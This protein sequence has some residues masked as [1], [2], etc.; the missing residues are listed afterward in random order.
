MAMSRQDRN[1]WYRCARHATA[2]DGA[3]GSGGFI[4]RGR[5]DGGS[6]NRTLCLAD[7][8]LDGPAPVPEDNPMS[9]AKV[10]LGRHLFYDSRLSR[11]GTIACASCHD[12][13]RGF[14]DGRALAV[15][16]DDTAGIRNV[17]GL[18]NVGYFP[19]LTWGNPHMTSLEFQ[20]LIPL[21]GDNPDEMGSNGREDDIFARLAGD[22]Y[23][24]KA[25]PEVF[26]E[27]PAI[28]LF[29]VTR[30]LGA[31]ERSLISLDSPYDRF[32]Y[33]GEEDALSEAAKR[34]EQ[35]FFDH[36]FECYH[37]HVGVLFTDNLQTTRSAL[38]ETGNHNTGL[39]NIDGDGAYPPRAT[40][41]YEFTGDP[42]DMGRFRTPSL[43]NVGVTA[44]ISM[45]DRRKRWRRCWPITPARGA[46]SP[47]APM[48][49]TG[50]ETLTRTE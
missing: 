13:A 24:A 30:A 45:T 9:A 47:M 27:R 43:R 39:Y 48:P 2:I 20:S 33:W 8:G 12:Q 17:P 42:S 3:S 40:G 28:D 26:P 36:R 16:I 46:R 31:F 50:P 10:E 6:G 38:R 29:T 41:F 11:D 37:C 7:A 21:F 35:L 32:K 22:P 49:V 1:S 18:A 4:R 44:P 19:V 5:R 34:G 25:F 23:Y 14:T 15:G